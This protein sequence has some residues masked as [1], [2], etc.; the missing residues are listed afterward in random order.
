MYG[1]QFGLLAWLDQAWWEQHL[2]VLFPDGGTLRDL[3][4]FAWNSYLRF[5]RPFAD[6]FP[7]MRFRYERAINALQANDTEVNDGLRSLGNHLMQYCAVGAIRHDDSLLTQ[8]F[9]KASPALRAQTIGD[10][11][12]HL[13]QKEAGELDP[14]I[15]KRLMDLWDYRLAHGLR[16]VNA[17]REELGGFGW[18]FAS[19]KFPEEWSVRQLVT[20]VERFRNINPDFAVVERLAELA[21][22][23]PYEAVRCLGIT[24]EEDRDGWAIHGWA[25][26]PQ[27][28]IR[29]ALRGNEQSRAEAERVVNLLVSRGHRGFRELLKP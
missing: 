4:R 7:A 15:R 20:V 14:V 18:W 13:G 19:K 26:N 16:H 28:I 17:S 21:P 25:E 22:S 6:L 2:P 1:M 29:E 3:D 27:T 23:Y 24:F 10:I 9:T 8:F 12:W 5:S 11:G